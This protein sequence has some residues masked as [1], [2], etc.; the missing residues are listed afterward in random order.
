[1]IPSP[2]EKYAA[3]FRIAKRQARQMRG[4]LYGRVLFFA[5]ILGVFSSLWRA[6]AEA[7]MPLA[8][9]PRTLVWYIAATEWILL[10]APP[11]HVDVQ[12]AVRRGDVAYH[13][14]RPVSYV[15]A[16]FAEGLGL[17]A[18]RAPLLG[19]TAMACAFAFTGFV[20][21]LAVLARVAPFGLVAAAL[22]TMMSLA[23][24]LLAFWFDEVTPLFWLWQ[25]LL[26]VLG[27]LMLPI[28]LYPKVIQRVAAFTPFPTVLGG[29]ASFLLG[30]GSVTAVDLA[31]SL[32]LWAV[33]IAV[34]TWCVFRRATAAL[35][36]N[37]G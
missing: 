34:V 13:L 31:W 33:V 11:L 36:F 25:K 5:V 28:Q 27:G 20:P 8:A 1:M 22:I 32:A 16:V 14:G 2:L 17:L 18:S 37:G 7:G 3:F 6:V 23:I 9:D 19:V 26:F 12:D 24:G 15:A 10:S 21:P 4:E 29:P 30:S 35:A